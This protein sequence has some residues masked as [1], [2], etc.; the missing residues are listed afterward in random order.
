MNIL[1]KIRA[2]FTREN[3]QISLE[4]SAAEIK[5]GK[6]YLHPKSAT[7][8]TYIIRSEDVEIRLN[9]GKSLNGADVIV[10]DKSKKRSS[11]ISHKPS[12][13]AP[14]YDGNSGTLLPDYGR[15][16]KKTFSV[17]LY[18]DEYETLL[19]TI[20]EYGYRWAD[21]IL[22]SAKTATKGTME[23]EHKKLIKVHKEIRKEERLAKTK[24]KN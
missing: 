15:F 13:T 8:I 5:N 9:D 1:N 18:Q 2:F 6:A 3:E 11:D 10:V 7:G 16:K 17:S 14:V 19:N 12:K 24:D 20:K 4:L 22:A 23:R 21:F